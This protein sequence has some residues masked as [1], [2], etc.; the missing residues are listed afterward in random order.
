MSAAGEY[1]IMLHP[2]V[3]Y[4]LFDFFVWGNMGG[5]SIYHGQSPWKRE[6]FRGTQAG[7]AARP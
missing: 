1:T 5:A 4:S 3:A 6:D 2:D 7:A